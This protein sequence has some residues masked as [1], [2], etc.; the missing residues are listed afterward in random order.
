[1]RLIYAHIRDNSIMRLKFRRAEKMIVGE[2]GDVDV[3]TQRWSG[4][5]V[6]SYDGGQECKSCVWIGINKE[7]PRIFSTVLDRP[8][9]LDL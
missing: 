8:V 6:G 2:K 1:L 5:Q 4:L 9:T 7:T 3:V